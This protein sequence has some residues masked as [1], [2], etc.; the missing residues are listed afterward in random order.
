MNFEKFKDKIHESWHEKL[1]PFIESEEC[2][3]IY[4]FLKS[5]SKRG[6]MIVPQSDDVW[7]C[8]KETPLPDVKVVIVGMCPYHTVAKG[9]Q[10]IADGLLMG[11]SYTEKLQPTLEQFYK[12]IEVELYRGLALDRHYN[13]DVLYLAKQGVLM[14]NAALTTELNK[15]GAHQALWEPFVKY[16]FEN[17]FQFS[18]I[19]FIFLGKDASKTQKYLTGFDWQFAISHPASASYRNTEWDTEGAFSKV[20]K[21]IKENNS[22][23]IDWLE[24]IDV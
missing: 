13:P 2:D 19:P 14:F 10:V 12:G 23:E 17:V 1:R 8:F 4:A 22:F 9:G 20:N 16:L 18:G 6:K 21:L 15:A 3:E 5:E 7:R 11:C 24:K